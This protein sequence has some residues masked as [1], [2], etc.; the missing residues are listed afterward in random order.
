MNDEIYQEICGERV[1]IRGRLYE[2][3]RK[4]NHQGDHEATEYDEQDES[5]REVSWS[6]SEK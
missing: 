6:Q 2:C 3:D 4:K 1:F 5:F